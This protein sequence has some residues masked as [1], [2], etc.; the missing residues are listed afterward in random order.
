MS[1]GK[2]LF[3][4]LTGQEKSKEDKQRKRKSIGVGLQGVARAMSILELQQRIV[5]ESVP[6]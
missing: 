5:N 4:A 6:S 2:P 3:S 1:P